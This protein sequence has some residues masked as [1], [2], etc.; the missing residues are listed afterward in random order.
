MQ[1]IDETVKRETLNVALWVLILSAVMQAVCFAASWWSVPI[2]L[3]NLLGAFLAVLNFLLMGLTVQVAVKK[4]KDEARTLMKAS[5][6]GRMFIIAIG[7]LLGA[8][9]SCFNL[10]TTLVPLLFPRFII[11]FRASLEDKQRAMSAGSS[12]AAKD[13]AK[14]AAEQSGEESDTENQ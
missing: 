8:V 6:A 2:L 1:K 13:T 12:P 9:F 4:D 3:G 5:M 10:Y 7:A 14:E 11:A